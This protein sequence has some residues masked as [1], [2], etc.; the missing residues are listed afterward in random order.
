MT[1]DFKLVVKQSPFKGRESGVMSP[2]LKSLLFPPLIL[3]LE[4]DIPQPLHKTRYMDNLAGEIVTTGNVL[5]DLDKTHK[6]FFL[7][8]DLNIKV[9]GEYIFSCTAIDMDK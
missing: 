1:T 7:F 9:E 3:E 4:F 2:Y 6:I 5:L 8:N